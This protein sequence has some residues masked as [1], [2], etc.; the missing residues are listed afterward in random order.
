MDN[1]S[2]AAG[3]LGT[4]RSTLGVLWT[5]Y[6]LIRLAVAILLV[7]ETGVA[8]VMFG[9]LL[10]RVANAFLFMDIFR[11]FYVLAIVLALIAG[12]FSLLAGFALAGGRP[13]ARPLCIA[14]GLLSVSDIPLGTTLGTYTLIIFL[15]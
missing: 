10:V 6:G 8:T 11:F 3:N 9:A 15:R 7:L 5:I 14:A 12:I 13:S 2:N 4:N 1:R